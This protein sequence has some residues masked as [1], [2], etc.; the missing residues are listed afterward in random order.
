MPKGHRDI[1]AEAAIDG[2]QVSAQLLSLRLYESTLLT[3]RMRT[4]ARACARS[5][6]RAR[7]RAR[8]RTQVYGNFVELLKEATWHTSRSA[9][10]RL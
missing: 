5:R 8:A 4:H 6:A 2:V 9:A 3:V 10:R 1:D 7:A